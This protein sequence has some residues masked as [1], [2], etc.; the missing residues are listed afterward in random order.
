MTRLES[1]R[2]RRR[3][4]QTFVGMSQAYR[5]LVIDFSITL[6]DPKDVQTLR[7][8]IQGVIRAL[9]SLHSEA[10]MFN[11]QMDKPLYSESQD[12]PTLD[13]FVVDMEEGLHMPISD[14][15]REMI[16]FVADNLT[17]PTE[18]LLFAMKSALQSCDAVLM[19]MCGHRQYLGP[20][21]DVSDD[22]PGSLVKLRKRI[23]AFG[24]CQ[25]SV[26]ASDTLPPTYAE[27]SE[28]VKLFAYCRPVHQAATAIEALLVKV[29]EMQQRRPKYPKFHLPSY[30]FWKAMHRTNA[31][32]RH[33]RGGVTAGSYFKSFSDIAV[34]IQKIKAR[35]FQPLPREGNE[36]ANNEQDTSYATMTADELEDEWSIRKNY[37][38]HEI[39]GILHRLQGFETRFGLK[40]AAITSLLSI[41]A[42]LPQSHGW[43]DSYEVWWAVVMAW[44]IMGPR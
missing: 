7:N 6:F 2:T 30:P 27:S 5:D 15:E 35:E 1:T 37:V 10:T 39:W 31:Q 24:N 40:T 3:L 26:L 41:P 29:N 17:E 12:R 44:L 25:D 32:V 23:M 19:E 21:E 11:K 18:R 28:V 14:E 4:T 43:W 22:V 13:E 33:D 9:L 42:W 16:K 38:R 36:K 20:P 34:I 8:R